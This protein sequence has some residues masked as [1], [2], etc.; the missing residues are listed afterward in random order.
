MAQIENDWKIHGHNHK[1]GFEAAGSQHFAWR[2]VLYPRLALLKRGMQH[3]LC[4]LYKGHQLYWG[5]RK[6]AQVLQAIYCHRLIYFNDQRRELENQSI[7]YDRRW[8]CLFRPAHRLCGTFSGNTLSQ[9]VTYENSHWTKPINRCA[10]KSSSKT[11]P[12]CLA[13]PLISYRSAQ[14][15]NGMLLIFKDN[16]KTPSYFYDTSELF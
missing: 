10:E 1:G 9:R 14:K 7:F 12:L 6:A 16:N 4:C 3:R 13:L 11:L 15:R 5:P 8:H 2:Q